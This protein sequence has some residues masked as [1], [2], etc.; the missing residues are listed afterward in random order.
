MRDLSDTENR[1][2]GALQDI[3]DSLDEADRLTS[4]EPKL[5]AI[6]LIREIKGTEAGG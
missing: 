5:K 1:L 2:M 6:N 4:E 3:L